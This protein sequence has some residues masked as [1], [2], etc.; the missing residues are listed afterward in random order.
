MKTTQKQTG[1]ILLKAGTNSEWDNCDFAII[2]ITEEWK[3]ELQKRL[4]AVKPFEGDYNFSSLNYYDSA[5]DFYKQDDEDNPD[6]EKLLTEKQWVYVELD[7]G[8]QEKLTVPEN[9]LECYRMVIYA[10][11]R[12]CYQAYG[13]HTGEKFWTEEF[14]LNAICTAHRKQPE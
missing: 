13:K 9:R 5:V 2:H 10:N 12:A 8:E 11:R 6:F 14:N 7:E 1:Y 3:Q 4:E